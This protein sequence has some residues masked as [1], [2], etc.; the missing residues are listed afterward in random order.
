MAYLSEGELRRRSGYRQFSESARQVFK[1]RPDLAEKSVFLSH[2]HKDRDLVEGLKDTIAQYGYSLYIDWEDSGLPQIADRQT[3]ETIKRRIAEL[4]Y[5]W[6]LATSNAVT[7]RW[8][9]WEIGIADSLDNA[10]VFI[11]PVTDQNSSFK[12]NEYLQLYKRLIVADDG[13]LAVF[14]PKQT[15]GNGLDKYIGRGRLLYG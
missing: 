8:V 6:V 14:Q 4:D 15:K 7:S 13:S 9:P 3:A 2:S 11:I 5:F 12:G 1:S 10:K